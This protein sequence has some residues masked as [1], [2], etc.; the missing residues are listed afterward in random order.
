[1]FNIS[2]VILVVFDM[3]EKSC[4]MAV[5]AYFLLRTRF[6]GKLLEKN[7]T[8]Q[9]KL[10]V[11]FVF[12]LFSLYGTINALTLGTIW[13]A[14]SHSGQILAGL[15]AGI[16][17]GSGVGA[18]IGIILLTLS[19]EGMVASAVSA[20]LAGILA[21]GY[22]RWRKGSLVRVKEAVVFTAA[23]EVVAR[24]VQLIVAADFIA[25]LKIQLVVLVPMALGHMMMVGSFVFVVNTLVAERKNH[26]IQERLESE[27][28]MARDIQLSLVPNVFPAFPEHEEFDIYAI[29]QP[30]KEVGGDIYDFFLMDEEHLCFMI[31]DVSGKGMPAALFM[32][33]TRTLFKAQ[34]DRENDTAEILQRVNNELC[35]GN[36]SSMFVTLFCGILSL[37]T[38]EVIFTNAGH[39]PP[40]LYRKNGKLQMLADKHGP[41][42]GV[43]DDILY[44][45]TKIVL[46]SGDTL[47]M[48]TDGVSEAMD[49]ENKMFDVRRLEQ[50]IQG[51]TSHVPQILLGEVMQ[52]VELFVAGAEQSDDITMLAVTYQH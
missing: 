48:Y 16:R 13:V 14:L 33:A 7:L 30:A 23:F 29:L 1:M 21:G 2:S 42:L 20:L 47:I 12:T 43:M 39:N 41:A 46:G 8:V 35:R 22:H 26:R 4:V 19:G 50:V 17:S 6:F 5:V 38:G 51:N 28:R 40:Y 9:Q 15:Y 37:H 36:D 34:A 10:L 24:I 3:F 11:A 52:A 32:S 31:G 45:S 18:I 25:M 44:H 27:L 49:H